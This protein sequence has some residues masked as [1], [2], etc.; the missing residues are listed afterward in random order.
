MLKKLLFLFILLFIYKPL[1]CAEINIFRDGQI[2][3]SVDAYSS[4]GLLYVPALRTAK[5]LGGKADVLPASGKVV[6]KLKRMRI[7]FSD[8]SDIVS[9]NGISKEFFTPMLV[10]AGVPYISSDYLRSE[11]FIKAYGEKVDFS[12][13]KVLQASQPASALKTENKNEKQIVQNSTLAAI[14]LIRCAY[15]DDKS[16]IVLNMTAPISWNEERTDETFTLHL[17]GIVSNVSACTGN[18]G[19]EVSN[20]TFTAEEDGAALNIQLT[21]TA[22]SINVFKLSVPDRLVIDIFKLK[23]GESVELSETGEIMSSTYTLTSPSGNDSID[24]DDIG[25]DIQGD[26]I[27]P[28]NDSQPDGSADY[29][30]YPLL[31]PQTKD[32]NMAES[33]AEN[34]VVPVISEEKRKGKKLIVIDPGHGGHDSGTHFDITKVTTQLKKNK[35]GK[36]VRVKNTKVLRTIRE[37][38]LNLLQAQELIKVFSNDERFEVVLTR[39]KDV[40]IPLPS[41]NRIANKLRA[42]MFISLHIN[43]AGKNPNRPCKASGFEIFSMTEDKMDSEAS[44]VAARENMVFSEMEE[45]ELLESEQIQDDFLQINARNGGYI[46]AGFIAEQFTALTPFQGRGGSTGLKKAN[47]AVLR[48]ARYPSVLV[49]TGFLCNAT[50]R[51]KLDNAKVR[52]RVAEAI[53]QGVVHYAKSAGWFN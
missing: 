34:V 51:P 23:Q 25:E 28:A 14:T 6:L 49:E 36:K 12:A 42:D 26:Y 9:T 44:E 1:Y 15:H 16:R 30:T 24:T 27:P 50:D 10:R 38:D 39:D 17:P 41:R 43:S 45:E 2:A 11:G 40:F 32:V 7:I 31:R 53:Y 33:Y 52:K 21:K 37:K 46:L 5:I 20:I 13:D 18:T 19:S 48:R 4:A 35:R 47:L 8:G 3:G 29:E 22:G